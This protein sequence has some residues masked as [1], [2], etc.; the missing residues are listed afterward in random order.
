M[1]FF[2]ADVC[3]NFCF[4]P[5][6]FIFPVTKLVRTFIT[7]TLYI[8]ATSPAICALFAYKATTKL[9]QLVWASCIVFSVIYGRINIGEFIRV[10]IKFLLILLSDK[11]FYESQHHMW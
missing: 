1:A 9:N 7:F 11:L 5:V 10:L 6:R 8:F 3:A 4:F 2:H